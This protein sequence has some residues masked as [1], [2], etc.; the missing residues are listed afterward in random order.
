MA[1]T[2]I[3]ACPEPEPPPP[4]ELTCDILEDEGNCWA[5]AATALKECLP[6]DEPVA[7][8]AADRKSCSYTDGTRIVF[9]DALPE[10]TIDLE[11]FAFTIEKNGAT[12]GGFV[13]HFENR[14]ELTGGGETVEAKLFI[15]FE[16]TC[17]DGQVYETEFDTLFECAPGAGPTDGFDV[18][19]D[20]VMFS[21]IAISTPGEL[22]RC[23]L[24][25]SAMP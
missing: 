11:R 14:M 18:G 5:E 3:A 23:Q 4:K 10:D 20:Y 22:F 2:A 12:C 21:I 17:G 19:P 1:L 9:E 15:D 7:T 16:L 6:G 24:D 25:P 8:F 13:D